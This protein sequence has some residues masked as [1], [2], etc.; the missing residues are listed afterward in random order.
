M[1]FNSTLTFIFIFILIAVGSGI[2]SGLKGYTLGH[3]ALQEVSQPDI[4]RGER[5]LNNE[6]DSSSG[7]DALVSEADLLEEV[8][9]KMDRSSER[10]VPLAEDAED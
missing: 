9:E 5:K 3:E 2:I 1:R 10:A 4:R 8:N 7:Q 6:D